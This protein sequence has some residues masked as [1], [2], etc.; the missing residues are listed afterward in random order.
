[1]DATE[2]RLASGTLKAAGLVVISLCLLTRVCLG[3][4]TPWTVSLK[5]R[6]V[7]QGGVVEIK[8]SGA[9]MAWVT[10]FLRNQEVSFFPAEDGSHGALLG[11]DLEEKPG[12]VGIIIKGLTKGGGKGEQ[13]LSLRVKERLFPQ[14]NISVPA[15][16][17]RIDE[18]TRKRIQREQAEMAR[19]WA[20]STPRRLWE[21]P[22]IA[23]VP[24]G[25]TAPFGLRRIING[26][27]RS[28]HGGV[29]LKAPLGAEVLAANHGQVVL[30]EEFFFS[31]R[32]IVLDHGGGLYTM[33]FH[34]ADFQV[35][36][37]AQVRKGGLIGWAGMTG[38]VTGPHLHWGARLNGA[39]VDPFGLLEAIGNR[40]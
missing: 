33:Y 16:F 20:F 19:L 37:G 8:V 12:P 32:S 36:K 35:E 18:T 29:D 13:P 34:L 4:E 15:A 7:S 14:E 17:D 26:S 21:G 24:G 38:R 25:I 10:G 40:Q 28:P 9:D 23:P 30:R 2:A 22:F 27:P 5:S 6:E 1:M 3:G 39:R 31:G 11:V